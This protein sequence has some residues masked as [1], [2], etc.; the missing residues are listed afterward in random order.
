[1]ASPDHPYLGRPETLSH[2][3]FGLVRPFRRDGRSDFVAKS[4]EEL[5]RACVGQVLGTSCSN[6]AGTVQGEL[7]WRSDFGSLLQLLRHRNFADPA[8]QQ[9]ARVY[10]AQAIQRWEP[11][12]VVKRVA[13]SSEDV[14]GGL[15]MV[16][17]MNYS[18]LAGSSLN[19]VF[20]P[21]VAQ[22]VYVPVAA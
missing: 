6:D 2:L 13:V 20:V 19:Q 5:V 7:P 12:V 1:M 3:G 18:I 22:V 16:I 8:T 11:R 4:D 15:A 9:L 17:K 14:P 21:D 10:V